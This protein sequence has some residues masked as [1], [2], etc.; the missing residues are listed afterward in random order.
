MITC[1]S[2]DSH[3]EPAW[4]QDHGLRGWCWSL[5]EL[6]LF[7]A[8]SRKLNSQAQRQLNFIVGLLVT[9]SLCIFTRYC[10]D[11]LQQMSDKSVCWRIFMLR[12]LQSMVLPSLRALPILLQSRCESQ[13]RYGNRGRSIECSGRPMQFLGEG[14]E[15]LVT[16]RAVELATWPMRSHSVGFTSYLSCS[17][18][19][20]AS[21]KLAQNEIPKV[22]E[23]QSAWSGGFFQCRVQWT[24]MWS[25]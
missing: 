14:D 7:S 2:S 16:D 17:G 25:S 8:W 12:R 19:A 5:K 22:F 20:S 4:S 1:D 9:L 6:H 18:A 24:A 10:Q 3:W 23:Q 11:Q 21:W 13:K 15:G